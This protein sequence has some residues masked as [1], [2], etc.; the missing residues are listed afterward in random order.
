MILDFF[1]L[2]LYDACKSKLFIS[3]LKR[4]LIKRQ[5]LYQVYYTK[6]LYFLFD[7]TKVKTLSE[8][9]FLKS[10]FFIK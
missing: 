5:R 9:T 7:W 4:D 6:K 1:D 2:R 3:T 10:S 8:T